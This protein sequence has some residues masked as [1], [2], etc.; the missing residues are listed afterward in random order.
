MRIAVTGATGFLGRYLVRRLT[1]EGHACVC[2]HRPESDRT[3]FDDLER[4]VAWLPGELGD[5]EATR[6]L[7]EGCDAVVHGALHRA[8]ANFRG[9]E[10]DVVEF[11]RRNVL[12]TLQLIEAARSAGVR[13]FVF[14]ATCAVHEVILD[15]RPL[16]ESHPLWPSSHY[17][18]HKAAIEKFVHSYGFGDGYEICSLRPT[19]IYGVAHPPARSRWFELVRRVT[20]GE[21]VEVTRGGKEVH[22]DDV[23]KAASVLLRAEGIAGQAF[24]CYDR[25]ISEYDVAHLAK[26]LSGSSAEIIG[27]QKRPKHEIQT[28]K[29]CALGM[30]FG[31]EKR[32]RETVEG[33]IRAAGA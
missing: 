14:I 12:G 26:D 24:N 6:A 15:D 1:S 16:D 27:D 25:Y 17:G 31:G 8:G 11:T 5:T 4:P 30:R 13:R 7:V 33:L 28:G 29:I 10:G 32:L 23:A 21:T 2:W 9:G 22:A 20:R 18:A 19:G 3:G